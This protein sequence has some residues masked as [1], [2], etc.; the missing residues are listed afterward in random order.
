MTSPR[1]PKAGGPF[2]AFT[3]A[4]RWTA[5]GLLF[6]AY[7]VSF[8]VTPQELSRLP[9]LCLL[10]RAGLPC[11]GCGMSRAFCALSHGDLRAALAF[12]ILSP[13]AYLVFLVL[14]LSLLVTTLRTHLR[15]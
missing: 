4:Q 11:Y 14:G 7:A 1:G 10:N 5:L 2:G 13:L 8:L 3:Q 15:R 9:E 6:C 12:N